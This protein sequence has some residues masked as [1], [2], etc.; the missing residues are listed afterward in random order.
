MANIEKINYIKNSKLFKIADIILI[1]SVIVIMSL[2]FAFITP[3]SGAFVE[4]YVRGELYA[5]YDIN[6]DREIEI[7]EN[8]DYNLVQ[9][10]N[11]AV[12]MKESDCADKTCVNM[13]FISTQGFKIVCAPHQV[14]IKIPGDA[15][16]D[17][18]VG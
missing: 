15:S 5:V 16:Y 14:V 11:G 12:R 1:V 9:I 13:G 6:T 10:Y 7:N 4:I 18:V 8:G 17:G 3:K 2:L